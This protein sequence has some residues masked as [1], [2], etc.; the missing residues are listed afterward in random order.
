MQFQ[1]LKGYIDFE[2]PGAIVE[3]DDKST[4]PGSFE[5]YIGAT[6]IYSKLETFVYPLIS[7]LR[8]KLKEHGYMAVATL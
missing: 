2:F 1:Q 8:P 5:I 3:Y 6:L 7:D 4:T